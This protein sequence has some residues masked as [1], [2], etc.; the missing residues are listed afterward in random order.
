MIMKRA[1]P[2]TFRGDT[3]DEEDAK[4]FLDAIEKRFEKNEKAE[5]SMLLA[6]LISMTY[7]GNR[8]IRE[9]IMEMSNIVSKLKALKLEL[10]EDLLVHLVLI[11]LPAQYS[12]FQV[13]YNCQKENWSLNEL[14]SHCV[15]EEERLKH[16]KAENAHLALT[17]KGKNKGKGKKRPMSKEA[18]SVPNKVKKQKQQ[19]QV[20]TCFFCKKDG[21]L[22]KDCTK[23]HAWR[24]KKGTSLALVCS[25]VNLTSVPAHTWWLDSGATTHIS[26]SMQGCLNCRKPND[27]ER[28]IYVGDGKSLMVEAIGKFR[29]LLNTGYYL[30]LEE[31]YVVPSFRWNFVSI[32]QLD[33]FGYHCSFGNSQFRLL[34]NSNVIA[35][36]SLSFHDNLYLLNTI[37]SYGETLHVDSRG[38]K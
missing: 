35:T 34:L 20:T 38:T 33:K 36:G 8:N 7:T 3:S 27:A 14:I 12:Q 23:Y 11:S 26:V 13:S 19:D 25:E 28:F 22:K 4:S 16:E 18:A 5:T 24:A 21:H 31:T 2:E 15:Q 10:S 17:S 30:D 9:Y 32:S 6:K 37:A 1:I 29:L